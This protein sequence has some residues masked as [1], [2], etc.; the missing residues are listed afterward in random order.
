MNEDD[1]DWITEW[2]DVLVVELERVRHIKKK[3]WPQTTTATEH[4]PRPFAKSLYEPSPSTECFDCLA[5]ICDS[6]FHES[7]F[8]L[9]RMVNQELGQTDPTISFETKALMCLIKAMPAY[10][11]P[12][13]LAWC[14]HQ[15]GFTFDIAAAAVLDYIDGG[16]R[17]EMENIRPSFLAAIEQVKSCISI[18]GSSN[19]QSPND[20]LDAHRDSAPS[21]PLPIENW[22]D[23]VAAALSPHGVSAPG[24]G[25]EFNDHEVSE[26]TQ[27]PRH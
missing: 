27:R 18:P 22:I 15:S 9:V 20:G 21:L 19:F 26:V 16:H 12:L 3:E 23:G 4:L 6:A 8:T 5:D 13:V 17:I 2:H 24:S 11:E 14:T 1:Y 25:R 7:W 10:V